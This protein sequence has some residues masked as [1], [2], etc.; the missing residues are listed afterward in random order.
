[1]ER[2][3]ETEHSFAGIRKLEV[4]CRRPSGW[5]ALTLCRFFYG[6]HIDQPL[7]C[8]EGD[9]R[10]VLQEPQCHRLCPCSG[11]CLWQGVCGHTFLG[12]D[13]PQGLTW[14][15]EQKWVQVTI[16]HASGLSCWGPGPPEMPLAEAELGYC[17]CVLV[18]EAASS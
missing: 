7:L 5:R 3:N 10:S 17:L 6:V 15:P 1:M 4:G 2:D 18:C 14:L 11:L 12:S 9:P 16:P 13:K 8:K